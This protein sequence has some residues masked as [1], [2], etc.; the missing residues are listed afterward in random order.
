M[1][2][3]RWSS[4]GFRLSRSLSLVSAGNSVHLEAQPLEDLKRSLFS[5]YLVACRAYAASLREV[6]R[7]T[8]MRD[9]ILRKLYANPL[10]QPFLSGSLVSQA[11]SMESENGNEG[12]RN[13]AV[14]NTWPLISN[15][16]DE[17]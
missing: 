7:T 9:K 4:A 17:A 16:S 2:V 8:R 12:A 10:A 1:G 3:G 6:L 14:C 5:T 11:A 15:T 13:I